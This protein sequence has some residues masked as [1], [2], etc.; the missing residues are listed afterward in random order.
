[1]RI[2]LT[3]IQEDYVVSF[4]PIQEESYVVTYAE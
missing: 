1:M 3:L 2:T 4:S